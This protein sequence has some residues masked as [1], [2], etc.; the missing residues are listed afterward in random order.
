MNAKHFRIPLAVALSL[1]ACPLLADAPIAWDQDASSYRSTSSLAPN[2]TIKI[3]VKYLDDSGTKRDFTVNGRAFVAK[4]EG[5]VLYANADGNGKVVISSKNNSPD[6]V[7]AGT[8][9]MTFGK[10]Q[11]TRHGKV[12]RWRLGLLVTAQ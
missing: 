4:K 7:M 9:V 12:A 3:V 1:A 6:T 2:A 11:D 10:Y 8:H 5:D